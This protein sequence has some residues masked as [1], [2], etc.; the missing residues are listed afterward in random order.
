MEKRRV[1]DGFECVHEAGERFLR[2]GTATIPSRLAGAI[3]SCFEEGISC[4]LGAIGREPITKAVK[5]VIIANKLLEKY[6]TLAVV[7]PQFELSDI[8]ASEITRVNFRVVFI[9][10]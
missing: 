9:D 5:G 1:S 7:C 10:I 2:V 6:D 4:D 3:V 8:V